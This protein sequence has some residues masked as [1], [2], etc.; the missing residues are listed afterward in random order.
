MVANP[1]PTRVV[2]GDAEGLPLAEEMLL[3]DGDG[4]GLPDFDDAALVLAPAVALNKAV[5]TIVT[6]AEPLETPLETLLGEAVR[7]R[8]CLALP[9]GRTVGV[10]LALLLPVCNAVPVGA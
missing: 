8:V 5:L 6:S 2:R 1:V 4:G 9:D 7:A 3:T 10:A